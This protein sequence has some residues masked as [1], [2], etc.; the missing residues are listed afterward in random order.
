MNY[1]LLKTD[2]QTYSIND[3]E[4]DISTIWDGVRNFQARNYLKNMKIDDRLVIYHSIKEKSIV[5]TAVISKEFFSDPTVN[6]SRWIA[7]EIKYKST[8]KNPVSLEIIKEDKQLAGLLLIKQPRLSV[9]PISKQEYNR[10]IDIS[11]ESI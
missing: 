11:K 2:P 3:L 9:M 1:W 4:E 8:F 7:V 10:I 5:G 6:D